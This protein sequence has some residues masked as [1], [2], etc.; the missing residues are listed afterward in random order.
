MS[1][2]PT[3]AADRLHRTLTDL[4]LARRTDVRDRWKRDLPLEELL[5]DRW[6]RASSLGFGEAS[7]IYHQSYVYGDVSIGTHSWVGPFT[8]LDGSGGLT[9][10]DYCVISA[11]VH[12]YTHDTVKWALSGGRMEYEQAPVTIGDCTY[13]GAQAVVLKGVTIGPH[14][15]IGA[16]SMVNRDIPPYTVAVGSPCR[17]AGRVAIDD[18]GMVT[19]DYSV[20]EE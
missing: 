7:S 18:A 13:I 4:Y 10:G 12:I 8:L 6:E 5:F 20:S 1:D 16:G 11:G 17:T 2:R 14:S 9:I 15:V 3:N 19:L